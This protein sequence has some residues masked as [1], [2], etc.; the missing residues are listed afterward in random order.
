MKNAAL[1]SL[2]IMSGLSAMISC[3]SSNRLTIKN[4]EKMFTVEQIKEKL[5]KVRTGADFPALAKDLKNIGISYYETRMED[6]RS[7]Y[8]G[9]NGFEL[10]TGPNYEV[11][12]VAEKVNLEQLKTD[13]ANHQHGRSDYFEI[14]RQSANSGIDKWGVCLLTMTCTYIDKAGNKVWVEH[15]PDVTNQKPIFTVEQ[16]KAAHSKVK[17]GT[18]FPSYIKEIKSLGVTHYETYVSDGHVDYHG[19]NNYTAKVPP[20]YEA[21]VITDTANIMQFKADLKVH[22]QGKSDFLT[23]IK[24]CAGF[25]IEKWAICMDKMICT[26]YDKAGNEILVEEIPQ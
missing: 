10:H 11:M 3:N 15:I 13:I 18:D 16:I 25:G 9:E 1:K 24:N 17:S 5:S 20:K 2:I 22:Q 8:H 4:Q 23:F 26:Y 7:L 21:L 12:L 6:G 19:A 14:S